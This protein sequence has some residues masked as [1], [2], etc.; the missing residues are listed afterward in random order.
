MDDPRYLY[1]TH[2]SA[3][4]YVIG[5]LVRK[6]PQYMLKFQSGK[7]DKADRLFLS[8]KKDWNVK[9]LYSLNKQNV[10]NNHA[11][12]KELIPEFFGEDDS[13]LVNSLGLDLGLRQNQKRVND[14]K[15]PKWARN[16]TEF[17]KIN[18]TGIF[19]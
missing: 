13:F 17:L 19:L 10:L 18:R 16:A 5:Y 9:N 14:V 3:P 12:V 4:G 2:Y 11:I 15:L 1:G 8:V 6:N 7:F